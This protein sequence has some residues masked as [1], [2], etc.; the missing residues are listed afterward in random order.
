MDP[1]LFLI[2]YLAAAALIPL[3]GEIR[4][5]HDERRRQALLRGE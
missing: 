1:L 3:S 4:A 2:L 5:K